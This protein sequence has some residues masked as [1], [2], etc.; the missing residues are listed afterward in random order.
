[1]TFD[2]VDGDEN[3]NKKMF[4]T[5]DCVSTSRNICNAFR[6]INSIII[7]V[8]K[9]FFLVNCY[10][11]FEWK[12]IFQKSIKTFLFRSEFSS[13]QPK[14]QKKDGKEN[15]FATEARND[16]LKLQNIPQHFW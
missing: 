8:I 9:I 4:Q 10:S 7:I 3:T 2:C 6:L 15:K 11:Y 5:L 1:M 16:D 14:E 13:T 12:Y